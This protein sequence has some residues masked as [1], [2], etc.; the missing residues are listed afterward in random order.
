MLAGRLGGPEGTPKV[1]TYELVNSTFHSR[2]RAAYYLVRGL[3]QPLHACSAQ[4]MYLLAWIFI[5]VAVGWGSGKALQGKGCWRMMDILMGVGGGRISDAFR[6]FGD[7]G[8][9]W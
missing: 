9:R 5:G 4:R 7:S 2:K 8:G 6:G 1:D 3:P